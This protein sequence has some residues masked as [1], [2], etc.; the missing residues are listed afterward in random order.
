MSGKIFVRLTLIFTAALLAVF[1]AVNVL[2]DPLFQYHKP[3]FGL[4][5]VV[6][7]ERYQNAGVI[8]YFDFDNAILG[9][10]LSE[11]FTISEVNKTFGG[12]SVKLTM[13]GSSIYNMTYQME[14]MKKRQML[15]KVIMCDMSPILFEAPNDKLKNPLPVFLYNNNPLDDVEYVWNFS[16]LNDFTYQAVMLNVNH[17]IPDYDTVFVSEESHSSG[18]DK[19]LS[20]YSRPDISTEPVDTEAYLS[21]EKKN[22]ALFTQYF[23]AMPECE[24]VFFMAPF[25]MLYWDE[26][27]RLNRVPTLKAAYDEACKTLTSYD[28]VKLYMWT[29]DEML[30]IMSDLDNYVDAHHYNGQVSSGILARIKAGQGLLTEKNYREELDNLFQYVEEFDYNQY[31]MIN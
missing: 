31:F 13:Y 1:A 11:N 22:L 25:S 7:N 17:S 4:E 5:P 30:G 23:D 12:D 16:V 27:T 2:V 15:P 9:T 21:L 14:L 26:Q 8:K 6:T 10:S 3:W 18:K 28:N 20:R 24:F 29:D 19:V